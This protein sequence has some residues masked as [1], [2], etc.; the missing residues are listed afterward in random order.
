MDKILKIVSEKQDKQ[1]DF[2]SVTRNELRNLVGT[3]EKI[4][5]VLE[6]S[7]RKEELKELVTFLPKDGILYLN[8]SVATMKPLEFIVSGFSRPE[9]VEGSGGAICKRILPT[10]TE[11][12]S[13]VDENSLLLPSDKIKP[14]MAADCGTATKKRACKNCSCGLAEEEQKQGSPMPSDSGPNINTRDAKSSCGSCYLGDAFRCSG[15]PYKGLP[16]FKP[17]EQV[18]IPDNFLADDL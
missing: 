15:C 5:W 3:F 11:G 2:T 18:Q 12:V 8:C 13:L 7:P 6:E 17:G 4:E 14:T 10:S 1:G 9:N 16:A